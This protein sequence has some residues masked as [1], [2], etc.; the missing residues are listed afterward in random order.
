MKRPRSAEPAKRDREESV[1]LELTPPRYQRI[2]YR[3]AL[4]ESLRAAPSALRYRMRW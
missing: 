1:V 2:R 3:S 4:V